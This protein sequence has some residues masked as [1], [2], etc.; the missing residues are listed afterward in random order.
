VDWA[1][2]VLSIDTSQSVVVEYD[3]TLS[4]VYRVPVLYFRIKDPSFRY[5]PNMTT[6]YR[7]L[8]A[9]QFKSQAEHAGVM[10][11]ITVRVCFVFHSL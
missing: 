1:K 10:G 6:L 9:G 4:P 8:I 3:I 7:H 11:G 2:A 5:P